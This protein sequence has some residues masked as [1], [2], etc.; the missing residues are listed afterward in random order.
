MPSLARQWLRGLDPPIYLVGL[1]PVL[2]GAASTLHAPTP[3]P[4]FEWPLLVVGFLLIHV[5]VNVYNDAFD[6]TT[7]ADRFKQHSLARVAPVRTLLVIAT[8]A[9]AIG[10]AIGITLWLRVG[11]WTVFLLSA[12]GVG[13][14]FAYH[15]PPLRLSHHGWGEAVTFL[16]F[17]LIPA[18]T[19]A[20]L[21]DG[22]V[23]QASIVPGLLIGMAATIVLFY[24]NLASIE[25]DRSGG[26]RTLAARLG[27]SSARV[28]G[29]ILVLALVLALVVWSS[30]LTRRLAYAIGL[31]PLGLIVHGVHRSS[32]GSRGWTLGFYAL[33]GLTILVE[34][35][36]A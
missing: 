25:K 5:A 13:L 26:K 29:L 36:S 27:P 34:L 24:H 10:C 22:H 30:D 4:L 28:L 35:S 23:P 20:S 17:G 33:V 15:A 12:A 7:P 6:A 32:R 1:F 3:L 8:T 21:A 31:I 18:L 16:G 19:T 14:V 9:L 11:G 2:V